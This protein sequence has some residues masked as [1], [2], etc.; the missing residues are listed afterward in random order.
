MRRIVTL[1]IIILTILYYPQATDA[2][3][4]APDFLTHGLALTIL[5]PEPG[6]VILLGLGLIGVGIFLMLRKQ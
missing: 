4:G 5:L 2:S 6:T 3:P 1:A